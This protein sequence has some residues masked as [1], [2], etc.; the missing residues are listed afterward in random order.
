MATAAHHP[1]RRK[2]RAITIRSDHALKRLE[3]LA[4]SIGSHN[5]GTRLLSN[6]DGQVVE[7]GP[8][9]LSR[10]VNQVTSPV[11]WDLC[12]ATMAD[13]GVTGLLELPPA[14]TL[15]GI[16][17]RNLKGVERFELNTPAQ[18]DEAREFCAAH[19]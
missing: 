13:L 16:A 12:M 15:T 19:A 3:L 5:P 9:Y 10:L 18:L 11:R 6:R 14:G 8:E 2:Q 4:R 7:S 17:K 1:P